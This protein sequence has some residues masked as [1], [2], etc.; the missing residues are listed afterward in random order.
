MSPSGPPLFPES[1]HDLDRTALLEIGCEE[2][3]SAPLPALR[4]SIAARANALRAEYRLGKGAVQVFGT[5][6]RVI[7]MLEE[8]PDEQEAFQETV[9]GPPARLAGSLPDAPSPQSIGFAKSQGV[10]VSE[11]RI[12]ESSRG[13][14][15]AVDKTA[16]RKKTEEVLPELFS[17]TLEGLPL[18]RTMRWGTDSGPFL[19]PILWVLAFW[20]DRSLSLSLAGIASGTL[21]RNPRSAG[22]L[23][24]PVRGVSHYVDLIRSWGISPVPSERG[25]E[26]DRELDL[27]LRLEQDTGRLSPSVRRVEDAPLSM[28][29]LDLVEVFRVVVGHFPESYLT[30]PAALIQTVLRVHQRFY[31]LEEENG[32]LSNCFLA[33][34]GNPSAD[35]ATVRT[36][37]EKVVRAR[38]EDA[39]YY[40]SRDRK[41][42]LASF[43]GDLGGMVFFPGVGTLSDKVRMSREMVS[44]VLE[45]IPESDVEGTGFDRPSLA[46][47]LDRLAQLAKADLATGLVREFPE[48]EGQVG[49]HYWMMENRESRDRKEEIPDRLLQFE[50]EAIADHYHPRHAQDRLPSTLHARILSLV[51][52][53]LHQAGG[54]AA[55]FI[56]SG[57][58]DPYALRRAALGMM[59][60]LRDSGWPITLEQLLSQAGNLS[61]PRDVAGDLGKFWGERLQGFWE[62]E[63]PILLV[64]AGGASLSETMGF[65]GSRLRFLSG[66]SGREGYAELLSL[67]TRLVN[68]LPDPEK[69]AGFSLDPSRLEAPSEKAIHALMKE[70]GIADPGLWAKKAACGEWETIWNSALR[71]VIPVQKMFEEVMVNDPD[72]VLRENRM[73]L[74]SRLC[75]AIGVLGR[76]DLLPPPSR[77]G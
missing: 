38:L 23:H 72:P 20:G 16:P 39:Q 45:R 31:V 54:L 52:K 12:V 61:L 37:Y 26:I 19:R 73:A 48:L 14:Y 76:L 34:S 35:L 15:L 71:F 28:E 41:R 67:Y 32:A 74:L 24:H 18:P 77:E 10:S 58:E 6:Q 17:R 51:D 42:S 13:A 4:S 60:V 49:A 50:A 63:Y 75:M 46:A 47:S 64:R 44:W 36:G 1:N 29:V 43:A 8:L 66:V 59:A 40:L 69:S 33:I 3:P 70:E 68:I 57:S 22:F 55:G 62:R 5:P 2:L 11:L 27:A 7:L 9:L 65:A 30:L 21:T 56:P 25:A 53:F